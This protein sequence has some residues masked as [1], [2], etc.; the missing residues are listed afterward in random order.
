M[1]SKLNLRR[2]TPLQLTDRNLSACMGSL[3]PPGSEIC[4]P[5]HG[6]VDFIIIALPALK[7]WAIFNRPLRGLY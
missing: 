4:R 3:P 5:F 7:C 1:E 6:L 2:M